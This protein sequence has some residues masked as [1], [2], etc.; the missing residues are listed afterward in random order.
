[1]NTKVYTT[2][3]KK[4]HE[5]FGGNVYVKGRISGMAY[6]ISGFRKQYAVTENKEGYIRHDRFTEEEYELFKITVENNY[7]GLCIFDY[8]QDKESN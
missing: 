6:A 4:E 8:K 2:L 3:I 1:M 7:K 5:K